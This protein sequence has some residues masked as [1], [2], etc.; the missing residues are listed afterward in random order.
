[1]KIQSA[2]RLGGAD[3]S[4]IVS[5]SLAERKFLKLYGRKGRLVGA[6]SFNEPRKLIAYRRTLRESTSFADAVAA[7]TAKA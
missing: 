1:V 7:A 2:G 6:L 3:E 5:G 4:A